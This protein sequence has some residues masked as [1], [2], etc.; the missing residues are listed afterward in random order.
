M[1]CRLWTRVEK[2]RS[3]RTRPPPTV[4]LGHSF[5]TTPARSWVWETIPRGLA[6]GSTSSYV[7]DTGNG[8]RPACVSAGESC[9]GDVVSADWRGCS[10]EPINK[11]RRTVLPSTDGDVVSGDWRDGNL[12]IGCEQRGPI[13]NTCVHIS[14]RQGL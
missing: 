9:A 5:A 11:R 6:C 4:A 3:C 14:T 8:F 12:Q 2:R 13:E 1:V 7:A 10:R